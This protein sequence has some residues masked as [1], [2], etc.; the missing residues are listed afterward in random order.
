[1]QVAPLCREMRQ[2][3]QEV[4]AFVVRRGLS[5]W[6]WL[7][8]ASQLGWVEAADATQLGMAS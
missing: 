4:G 2:Y 1:M 6:P 8:G 5:A 3:F 7:K